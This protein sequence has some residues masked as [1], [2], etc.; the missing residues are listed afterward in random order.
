MCP[1]ETPE[2]PN[3]GLISYLASY[4]RINE[5]GFIEG[6][7]AGGQGDRPCHR[8]GG[9]YDRRRGGTS[10]SSPRPPEPLDEMAAWCTT[11][12]PA[13]TAT[14][15]IVDPERVDYMD[16]PQDDALHRD[17]PDP[18]PRERR[19]QRALMGQHAAS[20]RAPAPPGGPIVATGQEHKI[21]HRL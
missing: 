21:C 9:L 17:R 1:I 13:V 18:L 5:Y 19:R 11:V 6:P 20:G 16:V 10:T 7:T 2:G 12:S 15:I 8:P 14:R 3:I 4:A